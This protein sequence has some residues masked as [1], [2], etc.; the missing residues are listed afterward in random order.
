MNVFLVV[1]ILPDVGSSR[2]EVFY[3]IPGS[4]LAGLLEI[5]EAGSRVSARGL[6]Y[7]HYESFHCASLHQ[8]CTLKAR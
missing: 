2:A 4:E 8:C 5:E 3:E 6:F 7:V 1:P